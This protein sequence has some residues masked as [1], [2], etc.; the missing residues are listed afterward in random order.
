ME[1]IKN[2][3]DSFIYLGSNNVESIIKKEKK[4]ISFNDFIKFEINSFSLLYSSLRGC[5]TSS[6]YDFLYFEKL[7]TTFIQTVL[8]NKIK[9]NIKYEK[10]NLRAIVCFEISHLEKNLMKMKSNF[11]YLRSILPESFAF[12][13][14]NDIYSLFSQLNAI[15]SKIGL[16][17][18]IEKEVFDDK[19]ILANV[20]KAFKCIKSIQK[21]FNQVINLVTIMKCIQYQILMLLKKIAKFLYDI[22]SKH[23]ILNIIINPDSIFINKNIDPIFD[24]YDLVQDTQK[25][26]QHEK[27]IQIISVIIKKV[28][29]GFNNFFQEQDQSTINNDISNFCKQETIYFYDSFLQSCK[30]LNCDASSFIEKILSNYNVISNSFGKNKLPKQPTNFLYYIKSNFQLL[31]SE[32]INH[33]SSTLF[34]YFYYVNGKQFYDELMKNANMAIISERILQ[35][36]DKTVKGG[37]YYFIDVIYHYYIENLLNNRF[38]SSGIMKALE[39]N[40]INNKYIFVRDC[41]ELGSNSVYKLYFD[42]CDFSFYLQLKY[43]EQESKKRKSINTYLSKF[44]I[45][46][47]SKSKDNYIYIPYFPFGTLQSIIHNSQ[48]KIDTKEGLGNDQNLSDSTSIDIR[49]TLVDKI[50]IILEIALAVADMHQKNEYNG[51]IS[52]QSIFISSTKNAYIDFFDTPS[53][54][55]ANV[56]DQKQ[57]DDIEKMK[58]KDIFQ[59]GLL[60]YEIFVEKPFISEINNN[61]YDFLNQAFFDFNGNSTYGLKDIIEKCIRNESTEKYSSFTEIIDSIRS[62]PIYEK[63]E[64]EIEYRISHAVDSKNYKCKLSD[65][66][67]CYFRGHSKSKED[68][69]HFFIKLKNLDS[70]LIEKDIIQFIFQSLS[71]DDDSSMDRLWWSLFHIEKI[72][73]LLS[74]KTI[75]TILNSILRYLQDYSYVSPLIINDAYR[76]LQIDFNSNDQN[77]FTNQLSIQPEIELWFESILKQQK[78]Y[79]FDSFIKIFIDNIFEQSVFNSEMNEIFDDSVNSNELFFISD[80]LNFNEIIS[81][82]KLYFDNKLNFYHQKTFKNNV[83]KKMQD[84]ERQILSQNYSKFIV[85]IKKTISIEKEEKILFPYYPMGTIDLLYDRRTNVHLEFTLIDKIVNILEI[86][87]ALKDLHQNDEYH[88]Y[89]S[90]QYIFINS[91]KDAYIGSFCYDRNLENDATKPRGPFYYRSP[92][93]IDVDKEKNEDENSEEFINKMKLADIYSFGVLMH[94][95]I[96]ETNPETRMGN[97]PRRI[98]ISILKKDYFKF[99]FS[100]ENNEYF[101]E[102]YLDN[103]GNSITGIKD[104]IERCMKH[105][106]QERYSS[107][108]ELIESIK[109]LQIY[110]KNKEEIEYRI[111]H[112]IDSRKYECTLSDIVISYYRGQQNNKNDIINFLKVYNETNSKNSNLELNENEDIIRTILKNF[113]EKPKEDHSIFFHDIFDFI[114]EKF[115]K[116]SIGNSQVIDHDDMLLF[117]SFEANANKKIPNIYRKVMNISSTNQD[118]IFPVCSL[119]DFIINNPNKYSNYLLTWIY[120]IAKELSIIHSNNLYHGNLNP[121]T[122]GLYFNNSTKS[123]I[124]SVILYYSFYKANDNLSNAKTSSNNYKTMKMYSFNEIVVKNQRKDIKQMIKMFKNF[125]C[126]PNDLLQ[127]INESESANQIMYILYNYIRRSSNDEQRETFNKN[128]YIDDF[129]NIQITYD[130]L[131]E[132]YQVF[133]E[134]NYS[135]ENLIIDFGTLFPAIKQF[136]INIQTNPS[137]PI[138]FSIPQVVKKSSIQEIPNIIDIIKEKSSMVL[139]SIIN[140]EIVEENK[141][142]KIERKEDVITLHCVKMDIEIEKNQENQFNLINFSKPKKDATQK[143][144][145]NLILKEVFRYIEFS[146]LCKRSV[147]FLLKRYVFNLNPY[148]KYRITIKLNNQKNVSNEGETINLKNIKRIMDGIDRKTKDPEGVDGN[149]VIYIG[150]E[151]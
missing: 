117:L 60:M 132:I 72:N 141:L 19:Q 96:T 14:I 29:E 55:N 4:L 31:S 110:V 73:F 87:Y 140:Q 23:K 38:I 135:F 9:R 92:E 114:I 115:C 125:N 35:V 106:P 49:F 53:L 43:T 57:N 22:H 37:K 139:L 85:H 65:I 90:S 137:L 121:R 20:K 44:I 148:F 102:C 91:Q 146:G 63:N 118:F 138:K 13:D 134:N 62:L 5:Q 56:I 61:K 104:I 10:E 58:L 41:S 142:V 67:E 88:C 33:I 83:S 150:P 109:T 21:I 103:K 36:I 116:T 39:T 84:H 112:A 129:S 77:Q 81:S 76:N 74:G 131:I 130:S 143:K 40:D 89:L 149:I 80:L 11:L 48:K 97:N 145:D 28:Q 70:D 119:N 113:K 32:V 123:L 45:Y 98:R 52:T 107:F 51:C 64:E 127:L 94:E 99:L 54:M 105:C 147:G 86:A 46:I 50:V 6:K 34:L 122:V 78:Y 42:K 8:Q 128:C 82:N 12:S 59:F 2:Q 133:C 17:I 25:Q 3:T 100:G 108:N 24:F 75:N 95:L 151:K 66:V 18:N 30:D 15:I 47:N 144:I 71:L 69:Q 136:L 120:F 26:N 68:I 27:T 79:Y 1:T 124:P 126:V 16:E 111:S 7:T 101:E 93:L